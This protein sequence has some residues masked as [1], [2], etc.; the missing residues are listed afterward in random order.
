MPTYVRVEDGFR[1]K[2]I[3]V[4]QSGGGWTT[5][6][7]NAFIDLGSMACLNQAALKADIKANVHITSTF[8]RWIFSY[9]S[10]GIK[11]YI[12]KRPGETKNVFDLSSYAEIDYV[13][14]WGAFLSRHWFQLYG[15]ILSKLSKKGIKIIINGGGIGEN[16]YSEEEIEK[17]R[18]CLMKLN[19]YVF[20]SRDRMTF[21]SF[22]DL[23]EHSY[24]GIDC[25]FWVS[26]A[27]IPLKLDMPEYIVLNF[28]K[29]PEPEGLSAD[30]SR[31]IV[32]THHAT[33]H[34]FPFS[35]YFIMK[36]S[37][38]DRRN[39]L[40]SEL[41]YDYLNLYANASVIYSDRV[42][43]CVAA[44][45][46]GNSARLFGSPSRA[47]LFEKIGAPEI[48]LRII[49]SNLDKIARE[50]QKHVDFLAEILVK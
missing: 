14:Q 30:K 41:P 27:Y 47:V 23:A 50:K 46:Y 16:A 6:I 39:T 31:L 28:D 26:D 13:V 36:K 35:Q 10:R 15:E 24:N 20:I 17:T 42:H 4:L 33:W 1:M 29:Q 43:A 9:M 8:G 40:I 44:L 37:Y 48:A 25:A 12:S 3:T 2:R 22:K 5:N 38:Y 11:R 49:R 45:S 18:E 21:D 32:R 34:N 7:G 19:P